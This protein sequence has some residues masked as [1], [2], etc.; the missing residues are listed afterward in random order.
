MNKIGNILLFIITILGAITFLIIITDW[1][2][3]IYVLTRPTPWTW[4]F[5]PAITLN[6]G[7]QLGKAIK[8][9]D[10][11]TEHITIGAF[12]TLVG[13]VIMFG[14]MYVDARQGW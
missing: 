9:K 4:V 6:W 11:T 1:S 7:F 3:V 2:G 12:L 5:I 13:L 8:D 14:M 10:N